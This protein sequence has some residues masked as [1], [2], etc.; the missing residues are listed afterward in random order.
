M[1]KRPMLLMLSLVT[2]MVLVLVLLGSGVA[3]AAADPL[4]PNTAPKASI[5][6][7]SPPFATL[8]VR[9]ATNGLPGP[10]EPIDFDQGPFITQG[11]APDGHYVKYYNFDVLPDQAADIYVLIRQGETTP[12]QGQLNIVDSIPGDPGYNDFWNVH[13]VTV[14]ADYVANTLT[15]EAEVLAGGYPIAQ[16]DT[17]VNCPIVPDGSTATLRWDAT[18]PGLTRGWYDDQVVYYFNF[19]TNLMATPAGSGM[20]P[21]ADITVSFNINPADPGGGPPSGF[22]TEPGTMQTHNVV[23]ALPG[24]ADYS[25]LWDVD[26]YDNASFDSVH[27]LASVQAAPIVA[28]SVAL[29]NCPVVWI[30]PAAFSDIPEGYP[31]AAAIQRLADRH[32]V[33]GYPDGTFKPA[34]QVLRQQFAKMIVLSLGLPVSEADVVP[35]DDVEIDGYADPFYPDNYIAVAALKGITNG[36]TPDDFSPWAN[37]L[38]A[39]VVTM[40]VRAAQNVLPAGLLKVPPADYVGSLPSFMG[41]H[42]ENMRIAEYNGLLDGLQGFG[43]SWDPYMA[44]T[45]GETAQL[46]SNMLDL[47][48]LDPNTAP[49][50]SIDRFSPPFATLF[51]RTATNGL[52]GPNEPIDFDQGPFITQGLAPDGH[53]VKYY[54]FDVLPDQAAD[55]Y[56]LIRQGETTPVQGQLNIVDSIPGDPGYNDFWNVHKVTVPADYVANTLTSEA[57]VMAA[58]YPIEQTDTIVNCPI[59][60][61]GSTAALRWDATDPGLT[62]GWYDDQVVYYFNFETNLMA[63]PAG[64]GMVPIADITVSFNI[65]PADPGGGPPSG[66]KTEP[67][68]MQTHN[69]VDALPGDA[70]YSPLWD[71]DVYDNASFDSVHDLASVQAAP[72]VAMSVALVNCP[73]VWIEP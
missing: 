45:R 23:D 50:A 36:T 46:L 48:P 20:V 57:E 29:V 21:I 44:A 51:V 73:V 47:M 66:F 25:P 64:S 3:V 4:D 68:T 14:P 34:G 5:D 12:V 32:I 43:A 72:I 37:I 9:T 60:P 54:N 53:Y 2:F 52:P 39:Q 8:F 42:A 41:V 16:T 40:V 11:L 33:T 28:A 31:Y 58:G 55:I 13:K 67:G 22:K 30:E 38:R 70:D 26:V 17:I 49:K 18:D 15:S 56:V 6:R 62:R 69:V 59:V 1:K 65:N 71:V 27:D 61:D 24:D 35:F 10:N 7:F 19:E 63:T